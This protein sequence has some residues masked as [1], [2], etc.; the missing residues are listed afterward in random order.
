MLYQMFVQYDSKADAYS[1]PFWA[2]TVPAGVRAFSDM[3]LNPETLVNRHPADFT[4]FHVGEFNDVSGQVKMFDVKT[5]LGLA[6]EFITAA[7]RFALRGGNGQVPQER[8]V[9]SVFEGSV[10]DDSAEQ[11]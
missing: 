7:E 9:A 5:N 4:L 2:L 10:G 6:S 11:L 8:D 1:L 3:A